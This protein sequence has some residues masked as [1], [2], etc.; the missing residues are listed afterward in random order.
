MWS[1]EYSSKSEISQNPGHD[2]TESAHSEHAAPGKLFLYLCRKNHGGYRRK[3]TPCHHDRFYGLYGPKHPA[4]SS[5]RPDYTTVSFSFLTP[6]TNVKPSMSTVEFTHCCP[7]VERG[8][9]HQK[10]A[11][12]LAVAVHLICCRTNTVIK[13]YLQK[14][15]PVLRWVGSKNELKDLISNCTPYQR[16]RSG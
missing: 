14:R 1:F 10:I 7:S 13:C 12:P 16:K 6:P 15:W 5:E 4:S 11:A 8:V 3:A 9:V 2:L